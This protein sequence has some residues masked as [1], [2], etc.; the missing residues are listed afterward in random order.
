M[1]YEWGKIMKYQYDILKNI[2]YS[3]TSLTQTSR[4]EGHDRKL[5]G[6]LMQRV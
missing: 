6:V 4:D 1:F 2:T 3:K 5:L